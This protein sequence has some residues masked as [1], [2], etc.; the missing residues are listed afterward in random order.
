MRRPYSP[1]GGLNTG[2]SSSSVDETF[3]RFWRSLARFVVNNPIY[4]VRTH[5]D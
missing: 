5:T 3:A 2:N 1:R 4:T